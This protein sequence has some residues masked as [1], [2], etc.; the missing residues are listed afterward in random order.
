MNRFTGEALPKFATGAILV[1]LV[2]APLCFI[3]LAGMGLI[4]D[5]FLRPWHKLTEDRRLGTVLKNTLL[6]A[7]SVTVAAT[8]VGTL[9]ALAIERARLRWTGLLDTLLL[10]PI[11]VSPLVGAVAWVTLGRPQTGFV[12]ALW[13]TLS[14]SSGPLFS[15]YSFVGVALV[16]SLHLIPYVYLNV[17]SA[18]QNVDGSMEEAAMVLGAGTLRTWTRITLPLVLPATLS[19]ALLVFVITVET[20]SVVGLL[21]GPAG[22]VTLPFNIYLSINLPPGDW[23][24]AALQGV[25]LIAMTGTLMLAYWWIVGAGG[26]YSTIGAKG[27]RHAGKTGGGIGVALGAVA[28]LYVAIAVLLPLAALTLQ[29]FLGFA[30]SRIDDMVFTL[31]NWTRLMGA[32]AFH[33]GLINTL[34]I[35]GVAATVAVAISLFVA[36]MAVFEKL[37]SLDWLSSLPL[38]FPGIVLG[39]ALVFMYSDSPVYGTVWVLILGYATQFLPFASRTLAAPMLQ[40]ERGVDEAGKTLGAYMW[41]RIFRISAPLNLTAVLGAWILTFTRSIR[42]LNIAIFLCTPAT[43]VLPLLIW[44]YM[45]QGVFGLAATLS[46]V[47]VAVLI[48]IISFA[49]YLGRRMRDRGMDDT[50][51]VRAT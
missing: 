6:L 31:N 36:H 27:F 37:R 51:L 23:G 29:S 28:W 8:I 2:V 19:S 24:Y 42:E 22:F 9:L 47:Q 15:I 49:Q 7:V 44:N 21:G 25:L 50:A 40:L 10:V 14:G 38:A 4:D 34:L 43:T 33:R 11:M 5:Q 13:R 12:N 45:E 1:W 3:V 35:G 16:I 30:T 26:K 46:L 20:F 32:P 18:L 17:R 41:R 48:P 39:M